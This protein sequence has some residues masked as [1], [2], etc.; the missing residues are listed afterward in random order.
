MSRCTHD[1]RTLL[2]RP[3]GMYHC[4]GCDGCMVVAGLEHGPCEIGCEMA[5]DDDRAAEARMLE[6]LARDARAAE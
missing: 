2:G 3:I 6:Q 4:P 5:D 1:P